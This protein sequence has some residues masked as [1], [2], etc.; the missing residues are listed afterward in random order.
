MLTLLLRATSIWVGARPEKRHGEKWN[1][2][3]PVFWRTVAKR[4]AAAMLPNIHE[5]SRSTPLKSFI[6]RIGT[7]KAYA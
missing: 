3:V 5:P 7:P 4:I 2:V 6:S 1:R